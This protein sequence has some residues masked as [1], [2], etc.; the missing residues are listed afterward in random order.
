MQR[1]FAELAGGVL[2]FA[3]GW[4]AHEVTRQNRP[5]E[6]PDQVAAVA[7][8][9][10]LYAQ[11]PG[12]PASGATYELRAARQICLTRQHLAPD[13]SD[14]KDPS[15][16]SYRVLDWRTWWEKQARQ[17]STDALSPTTPAGSQGR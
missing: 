8:F 10:R 2:L 14:L 7:L 3:L 15:E 9:T 11:L 6:N 12:E 5:H 13:V 16:C 4:Y 1:F 17:Y